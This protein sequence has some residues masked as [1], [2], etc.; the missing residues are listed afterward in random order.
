MKLSFGMK[1]GI[2][3]GMVL[4]A[5]GYLGMGY[6]GAVSDYETSKGQINM[7]LEA[8]KKATLK[9]GVKSANELQ[10]QIDRTRAEIRRVQ[11]IF[12]AEVNKTKVIGALLDIADSVG[13]AVFVVSSSDSVKKTDE[14]AYPVT[15]LGLQ[16][17][18]S[19]ERIISFL[20]ALEGNPPEARQECLI[21]MTIDSVSLSVKADQME[22]PAGSISVITN[23]VGQLLDDMR[24]YEANIVVLLYG[25]PE[26]IA[27]KAPISTPKTSSQ[28][29]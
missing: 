21:S 6:A 28:V 23:G 29:K 22:D 15:S 25:A 1:V 24:K 7:T 10:L 4:L 9:S 2:V 17:E 16:V 20:G 18:G 14:R 5:C 8:L 19:Y 27:K 12:P 26:S 3:A 11:S 13:V